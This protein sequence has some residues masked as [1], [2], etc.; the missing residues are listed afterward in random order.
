MTQA[1]EA[2]VREIGERIGYGRTMQLCEQLWREK[3]SKEGCAGGEHTTGPAAT[4]MVPCPC[5]EELRSGKLDVACDWCCGAL[6]VT[7]RVAQA[8]AEAATRKRS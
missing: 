4:F 6:R 1:E 3:L 8:I 5:V 7:E 2:L